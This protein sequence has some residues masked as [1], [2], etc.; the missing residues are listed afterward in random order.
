MPWPHSAVRMTFS[1]PVSLQ[2]RASAIVAASAWVGSGAG[3]MPSVRAN[4]TPAAKQSDCGI[5]S[6]SISPSSYTW[7][8]SGLIPW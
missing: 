5:A 1:S 4:W 2:R 6:A 3:T 8:M 7:L